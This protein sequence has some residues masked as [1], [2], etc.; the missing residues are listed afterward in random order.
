[1][2]ADTASTHSSSREGAGKT[3]CDT[4]KLGTFSLL[5][6]ARGRSWINPLYLSSDL[7]PNFL[8]ELSQIKS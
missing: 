1:M 4:K 2:A 7:N 3:E 5:F 8:G 6:L